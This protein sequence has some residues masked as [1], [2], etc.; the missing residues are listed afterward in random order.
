VNL[1]HPPTSDRD[2][3]AEV[4]ATV[5]CC[6]NANRISSYLLQYFLLF[7]MAKKSYNPLSYSCFLFLLSWKIDHSVL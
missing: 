1:G 6:T 3:R 2:R 5:I 7:T 4:D